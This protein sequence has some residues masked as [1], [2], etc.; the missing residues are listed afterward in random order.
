MSSVCFLVASSVS[1]SLNGTVPDSVVFETLT[2]TQLALYIC[3]EHC[4]VVSV[5][6]ERNCS[7][8]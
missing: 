8:M 3:W 4:R 5:L 6:M 2:T 1:L 7:G